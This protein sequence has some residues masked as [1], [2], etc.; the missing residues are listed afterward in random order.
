MLSSRS[1]AAYVLLACLSPAALADAPSWSVRD[2]A[3][4]LLDKHVLRLP[5]S[6]WFLKKRDGNL[7]QYEMP[8][9]SFKK[10]GGN[11]QAEVLTVRW[12][13]RKEG[14]WGVWVDARPKH[15]SW[16]MARIEISAPA[17]GGTAAAFTEASESLEGFTAPNES[18]V[19]QVR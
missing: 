8:K 4:K 9:L 3:E 19:N 13:E 10:A 11:W 6:D 15:S 7:V 14:K 16:R 1:F 17:V 2:A 5:A 18:Y 12:R